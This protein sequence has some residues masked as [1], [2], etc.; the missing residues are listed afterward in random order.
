MRTPRSDKLSHLAIEALL[1][2]SVLLS[3]CGGGGGGGGGGESDDSSSD[4]G[5]RIL[6]AAIDGS[7]MDLLS[8]GSPE[9]KIGR[10]HV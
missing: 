10:A 4:S 1:V 8:S 7:P 3:A 2:C 5:V 6:H 9:K